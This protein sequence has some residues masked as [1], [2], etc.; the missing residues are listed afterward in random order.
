MAAGITFK[1]T[2]FTVIVTGFD[3][4]QAQFSSAL[5]SHT[6]SRKTEWQQWRTY[7]GVNF[8]IVS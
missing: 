5:L 1:N 3:G 8:K 6:V 7:N 4:G 2:D